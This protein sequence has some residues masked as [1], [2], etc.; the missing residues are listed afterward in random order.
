M[1]SARVTGVTRRWCNVIFWSL[2]RC[3]CSRVW[4]DEPVTQPNYII[5]W[6]LRDPIIQ[7]SDKHQRFINKP[8]ESR[9]TANLIGKRWTIARYLDFHH[10]LKV[11]ENIN[12]WRNPFWLGLCNVLTP[13]LNFCFVRQW[14]IKRVESRKKITT[15][16]NILIESSF[17]WMKAIIRWKFHSAQ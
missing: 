15:C 14:R 8:L 7:S 10:N 4:F 11:F 1:I 2:S 9:E 16:I 5:I 12:T 17:T 13:S 6:I 3:H